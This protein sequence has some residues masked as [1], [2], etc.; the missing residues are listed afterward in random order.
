[1]LVPVIIATLHYIAVFL[2]VGAV[3]AQMYLLKL[4][5]SADAVRG[6]ARADIVF[7]IG[8]VAILIS[9]FG[10]AAHAKG[11]AYYFHNGAFHLALTLFI[12]SALLSIGPTIRYRRWKKA[13]DAGLPGPTEPTV[14]LS[15][16]R[17]RV[18]AQRG[19]EGRPEKHPTLSTPCTP[20]QYPRTSPH[21]QPATASPTCSS[22]SSS[23][24]CITS[25]SSCSSA[26]CSR[27]CTCS[28]CLAFQTFMAPRMQPAC[29]KPVATEQGPGPA[30]PPRSEGGAPLPGGGREATQ[31]VSHS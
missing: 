16:L 28:S 13:V 5:P 8:A 10:N 2:L 29:T 4:P 11:M 6:I 24:R 17:E 21:L 18:P 20:P 1:M 31:G 30:A 27:R 22:P 9:G 14:P 19:R 23:P 26:P 3:F 25:P 7:G 12:V 15:R